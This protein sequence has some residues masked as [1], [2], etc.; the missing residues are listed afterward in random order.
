MSVAVEERP[1][2]LNFITDGRETVIQWWKKQKDKLV[3]RK[4]A[5]FSKR[6]ASWV[7]PSDV[8]GCSS[9]F[10]VLWLASGSTKTIRYLKLINTIFRSTL[11]LLGAAPQSPPFVSHLR[12]D[13]LAMSLEYWFFQRRHCFGWDTVLKDKWNSAQTLF[14]HCPFRQGKFILFFFVWSA[15]KSKSLRYPAGI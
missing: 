14:L 9:F 11:W 8:W 1:W 7:I 3:T 6:V 13:V 15:T 12:L 4:K 2:Y 5:P 10:A